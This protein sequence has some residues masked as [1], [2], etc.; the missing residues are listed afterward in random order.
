M[1][2]IYFTCLA[3]LLLTSS[4]Q[5]QAEA[6][7]VAP[8]TPTAAG[9]NSCS[10]IV[11]AATANAAAFK[12]KLQES[13]TK[14]QTLAPQLDIAQKQLAG[15]LMIAGVIPLLIKQKALD[16]QVAACKKSVAS[17]APATPQ[18]QQAPP[19]VATDPNNSQGPTAVAL[20]DGA[21]PIPDDIIEQLD[22]T[23]GDLDADVEALKNDTGN[24][25]LMK[26]LLDKADEVDRFSAQLGLDL[27]E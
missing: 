15:A 19:Q 8:V 13:K 18:N 9:A 21:G 25:E 24:L 4:E 27:D 3:L 17:S 2:Y 11:K 20:S 14:F 22:R 12:M 16:A 5:S 7:Q 10:D 6:A 1:Q 23:T 26:K